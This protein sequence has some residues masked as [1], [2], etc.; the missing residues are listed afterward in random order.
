MN[1]QID[2]QKDGFNNEY[3][4]I[5]NIQINKQIYVQMII[6]ENKYIKKD[7][8]ADI[9]KKFKMY[10]QMEQQTNRK[11]NGQINIWIH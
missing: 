4:Q 6:N 7:E 10:R 2:E 1:K 8:L 9:K 11:I 3:R 5:I